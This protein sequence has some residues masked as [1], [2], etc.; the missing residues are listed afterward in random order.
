[1]PDFKLNG[2]TWSKQ[3]K[4]LNNWASRDNSISISDNYMVIGNINNVTIYKNIIPNTNTMEEVIK[5]NLTFLT[6][7]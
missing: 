1:M 4:I 6:Y 2:V 3:Q 7:K 5:R